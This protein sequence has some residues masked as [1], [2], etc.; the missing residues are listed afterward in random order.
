MI[1]K[2][3]EDL[4]IAKSKVVQPV[5]PRCPTVCGPKKDCPPCPSCARCP[6]PKDFKCKKVPNYPDFSKKVADVSPNDGYANNCAVPT[7][8][9]SQY[10]HNNQY[11]P[12]PIVSSFSTFG[13]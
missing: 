3:D 12:V 10:R 4:Y 9:Y 1:P 11:L 2:G 13:M 8:D 5:C 7:S 6:E